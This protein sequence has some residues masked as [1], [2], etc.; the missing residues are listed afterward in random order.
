MKVTY[1][2][3]DSCK[4]N[5]GKQTDI[6]YPNTNGQ[7]YCNECFDKKGFSVGEPTIIIRGK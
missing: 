3:C 6:D 4:K 1:Y 5:M 7:H 2:E